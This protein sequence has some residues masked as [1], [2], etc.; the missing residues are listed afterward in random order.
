VFCKI[1]GKWV[2]LWRAVDQDGE[3]LDALVQQRHNAEAA[4]RLFR[5]LLKG[6]RYAPR[7]LVTDK[8]AGF[9]VAREELEMHPCPGQV[10]PS[11]VR[12]KQI[13][14][15]GTRVYVLR[16]MVRQ[17]VQLTAA[18]GDEWTRHAVPNS[19]RRAVA[20]GPADCAR[21]RAVAVPLTG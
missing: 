2:Y 20:P 12:R 7:A 21:P 6:L 19:M 16:R 9:T 3:T 18:A 1:N 4:R 10:F 14:A 8:L 11:L 15:A 13:G 5:K 17:Q